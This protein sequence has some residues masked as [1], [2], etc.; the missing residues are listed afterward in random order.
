MQLL[1]MGIFAVVMLAAAVYAHREL[2]VFT[3]GSANIMTA[4][5]VLL[6]VGAL[7]GWLGAA[8]YEEPAGQI[9]RFCIGFGMVH[10]PAAVIL[11]IK[12]RRGAGKS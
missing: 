4:R 7:F 6:I 11:F 9:L 1:L 3:R 12:G 8:A 2:P 10:V 5:L